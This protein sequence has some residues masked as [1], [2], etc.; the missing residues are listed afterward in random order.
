MLHK[1]KQNCEAVST[2]IYTRFVSG[3]TAFKSLFLLWELSH[4]LRRCFPAKRGLPRQL[5][6]CILIDALKEDLKKKKKLFLVCQAFA[7]TKHSG[8][9]KQVPHYC[10]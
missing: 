10:E 1:P 6:V 8:Y 4:L 3:E 5:G 9:K 2:L 7:Q